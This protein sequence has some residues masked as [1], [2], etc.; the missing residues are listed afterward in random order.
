MV[1]R[2]E[3]TRGEREEKGV[4]RSGR[5]L[6]EAKDCGRIDR[7]SKVPVRGIQIVRVVDEVVKEVV[8]GEE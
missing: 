6:R 5:K 2:E 4:N 1:R 7:T 3:D 8:V